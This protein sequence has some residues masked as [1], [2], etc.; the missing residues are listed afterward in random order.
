MSA[1][2]EEYQYKDIWL[3][4]FKPLTIVFYFK[5]LSYVFKDNKRV[6]TLLL[7]ITISECPLSE[8]AIHILHSFGTLFT[9]DYN[10]FPVI[11]V[12]TWE[13]L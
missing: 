7:K 12:F 2:G 11:W 5:R 13:Q 1:F 8:T 4:R 9:P 10:V 6:K 3:Y